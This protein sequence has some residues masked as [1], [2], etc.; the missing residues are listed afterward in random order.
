MA[1]ICE[2]Y[3][4]GIFHKLFYSSDWVV[5]LYALNMV[6][7]AID[8]SLYFRYRPSGKYESAE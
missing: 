6:L 7:I 5:S 2:G 8:L 1:I 4:S 3:L